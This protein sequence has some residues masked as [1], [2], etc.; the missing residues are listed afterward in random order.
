MEQYV[1][2]WLFAAVG[3]L[4]GWLIKVLWDAVSELKRDLGNLE[5]NLPGVYVRRDDFRDV[6]RELKDDMRTGFAKIEAT[7]NVLFKRLDSKE[8]K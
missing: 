6:T 3:A 4:T 7:L 8:D 1:I 2:N 5:R